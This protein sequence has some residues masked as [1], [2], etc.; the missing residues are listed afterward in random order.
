MRFTVMYSMFYVSFLSTGCFEDDCNPET[1]VAHCDGNIAMTCSSNPNGSGNIWQQGDCSK[2]PEK[3]YC[4]VGT[5]VFNGSKETIASCSSI[6]EIKTEC[7]EKGKTALTFCIDGKNAVCSG[8]GGAVLIRE[9]ELCG[10][11]K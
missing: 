2:V 4:V 5:P 9:K 1:D 11:S 6:K 7:Y 3:P 10:S 8:F